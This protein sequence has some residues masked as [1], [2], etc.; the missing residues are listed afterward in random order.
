MKKNYLIFSLVFGLLLFSL[1]AFGEII[2]N[3]TPSG[4]TIQNPINF[5]ISLDVG[6]IPAGREYWHL[7]ANEHE[8]AD[9]VVL[10]PCFASTTL[11]A[12]E[13]ISLP[14]L[15]EGDYYW[16]VY[17]RSWDN[18]TCEGGNSQTNLGDGGFVVEEA[19]PA[20]GGWFS[21]DFAS[22][23]LAYIGNLF[24]DLSVPIY[25]L[26]GIM[27]GMWLIDYLLGIFARKRK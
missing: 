27:L 1:P 21:T 18:D 4:Y 3:R 12:N 25:I 19:T 10:T 7:S 22:N 11:S 8:S 26:I 9:W 14:I 17:I 5:S 24:T 23:T 20:T 2:Y 15:A 6:D 16:A 13:N